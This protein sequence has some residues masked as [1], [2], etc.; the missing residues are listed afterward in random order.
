MCCTDKINTGRN[1]GRKPAERAWEGGTRTTE[2]PTVY[3]L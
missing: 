1:T 3:I 2:M